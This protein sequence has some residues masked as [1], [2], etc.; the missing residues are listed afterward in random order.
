MA[1]EKRDE[2]AGD[3]IKLLLGIPHAQQ[4]NEMMDNF[5]QIL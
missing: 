5:S 1:E 2:G 4:R 3:P